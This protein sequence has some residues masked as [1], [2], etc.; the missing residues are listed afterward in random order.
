MNIGEA[1][2]KH[3]GPLPAGAWLVAIVGGIGV[4]VVIRRQAASDQ[5]ASDAYAAG[6]TAGYDSV[7]Q[8]STDGFPDVVYSQ[9]NQGAG[10]L[11]EPDPGPSGPIKT[12]A[13]WRHRVATVL[14]A[15]GYRA[16][17]VEAALARYFAS[18]SLNR[19]QQEIISE[20]FARVGAPPKPPKPGPKH[21][22]TPRLTLGTLD[23]NIVTTRDMG[24][25]TN[26]A[27]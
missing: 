5:I 27:R 1:L 2:S 11:Y 16:N 25:T 3:Y 19:A 24:A 20:A 7:A 10:N 23:H 9:T 6:E 21:A 8:D 4:A 15:A 17:L 14:V 26:P 18:K 12:N 13:Q 22:T